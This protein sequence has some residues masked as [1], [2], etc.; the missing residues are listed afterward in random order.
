M[1]VNPNDLH[2]NIRLKLLR[3]FPC[4]LSGFQPL[5]KTV[6]EPRNLA[7]N[8][9]PELAYFQH[10]GR[11]AAG[12]EA[13]AWRLG[14]IQLVKNSAEKRAH[15]QL[16]R[17][18]R[19]QGIT[20][21]ANNRVEVMFQTFKVKLLFALDRVVKRSIA[22]SHHLLEFARGGV[23][24]SLLPKKPGG[25]VDCLLVIKFDSTRHNNILA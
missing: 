16:D 20:S 18:L 12:Y 2:N 15:T 4:C 13:Q 9:T 6:L 17:R 24:V 11:H 8:K 21:L 3:K 7:R 10:I 14:I 19:K 5:D 1:Y 25:S 23:G 22:N